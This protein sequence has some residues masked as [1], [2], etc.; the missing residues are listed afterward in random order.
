MNIQTLSFSK[1]Y[2]QL[3]WFSLNYYF[4]FVIVVANLHNE[5]IILYHIYSYYNSQ[6]LIYVL[7]IFVQINISQ[8]LTTNLSFV[9]CVSNYFND[10][11]LELFGPVAGGTNLTI[12]T[13]AIDEQELT[14]LIIKPTCANNCSQY[15]PIRYSPDM[16]NRYFI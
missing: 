15:T 12:S 1:E 13:K 3:S 7:S 14:G 9:S 4:N 8:F 6:M 5:Y 16:L 2:I 11:E 10:S